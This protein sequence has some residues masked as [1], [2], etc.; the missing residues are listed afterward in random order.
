MYATT[1]LDSS[2]N[3]T[4]LSMWSNPDA[5]DAIKIIG[6]EAAEF[7]PGTSRVWPTVARWTVCAQAL[8]LRIQWWL[9]RGHIDNTQSVNCDC[10]EP[11]KVVHLLAATW[12]ALLPRRPHHRHRAGKGM[13]PEVATCWVKDTGEVA[14][15][16]V[17]D[18]GEEEDQIFAGGSCLRPAGEMNVGVELADG[19]ARHT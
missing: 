11:Q 2:P 17:K 5:P 8:A 4:R 6:L 16:W 3:Y 13:C 7:I 10:C 15:C 19:L 9:K 12:W 18:T 14:T 1:T